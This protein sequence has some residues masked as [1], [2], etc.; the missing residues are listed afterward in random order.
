MET[1]MMPDRDQQ[2]FDSDLQSGHKRKKMAPHTGHFRNLF[3]TPTT[4]LLNL[5]TIAETL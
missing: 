5:P 4:E 2:L 3:L 1:A